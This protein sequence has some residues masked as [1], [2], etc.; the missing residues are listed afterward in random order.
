MPDD[1]GVDARARARAKHRRP[2]AGPPFECIA[3]GM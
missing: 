3:R 1:S 2:L